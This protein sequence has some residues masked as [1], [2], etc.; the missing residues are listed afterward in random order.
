MES[1][2]NRVA[3]DEDAF[4]RRFQACIG[5][6]VSGELGNCNKL[7]Q[8]MRN[9]PEDFRYNTKRYAFAN[10]LSDVRKLGRV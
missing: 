9:Y 1:R 5:R 10:T 6:R 4:V 8:P 3:D 7:H 2:W